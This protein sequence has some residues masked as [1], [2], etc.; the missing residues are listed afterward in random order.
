MFF[1]LIW[2]EEI[3]NNEFGNFVKMLKVSKVCG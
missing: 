1:F 2:L 3:L